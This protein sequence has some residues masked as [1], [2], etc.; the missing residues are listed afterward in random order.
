MSL[1]S[2][3]IPCYN[4]KESIVK[5]IDSLTNQ[6]FQDFDVIII[7]D[8]SQDDTYNFLE[9]YLSNV[10]L[11]TYLLKNEKN[12]GP[13]FSRN[14]GIS[15]SKSTYIAF[16]DSD[17]WY[18][19]NYLQLMYEA[20]VVQDADIVFSN[21]RRVFAQGK[22]MPLNNISGIPKHGLMKDMLV[23]GV[24]SLGSMIVKRS[25]ISNY[26]IPHLRNGEDMAVI[27][28]L[29]AHSK[30]FGF[31][32]EH[33]YNYFYSGNSL[34]TKV[35]QNVIDSLLKSFDYIE[36]NLSDELYEEC[37]YLGIRNVLY[38]AVLNT[39]KIKYQP[40]V[41]KKIIDDFEKKYPK[42]INNKHLNLLPKQKKFFLKLIKNRLYFGVWFMS[43]LHTQLLKIRLF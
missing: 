2:V 11:N 8:C 28:V 27:P 38:G 24:D 20:A 12:S 16:C 13:A 25:I 6:T 39:F 29:I 33:I 31:V 22:T 17:D 34:S 5:C 42:W 10:P 18:E 14:K 3:I 19:R 23:T 40:K 1:F 26:K 9:Q 35:S 32:E 36:T 30:K 7:D 15:V 21:S 41:A 37:E 4:S 43:K